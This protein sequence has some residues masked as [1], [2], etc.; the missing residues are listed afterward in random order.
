MR[1]IHEAIAQV[2]LQEDDI[3]HMSSMFADKTC[4]FPEENARTL[5]EQAREYLRSQK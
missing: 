5:S 1:D 4:M 2:E 3:I